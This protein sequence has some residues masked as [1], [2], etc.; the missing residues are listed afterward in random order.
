MLCPT[1]SAFD[2]ERVKTQERTCFIQTLTNYSFDGPVF[3]AAADLDLREIPSCYKIIFLLPVCK[4]EYLEHVRKRNESEPGK[5]GQDEERVFDGM[6]LLPRDRMVATI[7]F[8][9]DA[10]DID[11]LA[12]IILQRLGLDTESV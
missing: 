9:R 11:E 12:K 7:D 6:S 5:A 10:K 8:L 1:A 2:L 3:V 4:K